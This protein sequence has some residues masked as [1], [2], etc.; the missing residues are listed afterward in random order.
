MKSWFTAASSPGS[1]ATA[2]A[3]NVPFNILLIGNNA[4]KATG[5]LSLG[6]ADILML[7]HVDPAQHKVTLISVPRDL[8]IALP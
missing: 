5:P 7:A 2:V 6:Q 4:R 1:H 3:T 8:L